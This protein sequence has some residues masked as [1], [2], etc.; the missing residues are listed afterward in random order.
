MI[1]YNLI[2][3]VRGVIASERP[4]IE[5]ADDLSTEQIFNDAR[6]QLI[7]VCEVVKAPDVA[8]VYAHPL[9]CEA[10]AAWLRNRL[11]D[12][13]SERW[14]KAVNKKRRPAKPEHRSSHG[15]HTSVHRLVTG[16]KKGDDPPPS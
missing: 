13:W 11:R 6:R 1:L 8:A 16:H 3:V 15:A 7:A 2:Q 14:R 4:E 9:S 5:V 12:V 10:M